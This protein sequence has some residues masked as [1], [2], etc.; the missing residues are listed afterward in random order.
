MENDKKKYVKPEAEIIAFECDDVIL[1][2]DFG[3]NDIQV[4]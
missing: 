2:S 3:A 1:T 4:N